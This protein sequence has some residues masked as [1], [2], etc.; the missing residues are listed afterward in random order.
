MKKSLTYWIAALFPLL[1][2][3]TGYISAFSTPTV[4]YM[5]NVL[6]HVV[7]GAILAIALLF[8][9]RRSGMLRDA[10]AAIAFLL[11]AFVFGAILALGR[12]CPRQLVDT[13]VAHYGGRAR[14]RGDDPVCLEKNPRG[15]VADGEPSE[16]GSTSP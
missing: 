2:V 13:L 5:T 10:F 9:A 8:I 15:R 6:G 4:F 1:L 7:L 11:A 16:K 14:G 12:E 3:N